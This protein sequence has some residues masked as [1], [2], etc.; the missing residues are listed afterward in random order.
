MKWSMN[1]TQKS[2]EAKKKK[3]FHLVYLFLVYRV[4]LD[5]KTIKQPAGFLIYSNIEQIANLFLFF[6]F[7]KYTLFP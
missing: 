5:Q 1:P 4:D 2:S 3:D 7:K 6:L